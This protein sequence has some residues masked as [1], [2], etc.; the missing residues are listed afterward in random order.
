[1]LDFYGIELC[2]DHTGEVSKARNWRERFDNLNWYLRIFRQSSYTHRSN[3]L[4]FSF[5][6][7]ST[8]HTHN[9][10]RITRIIK[11][12]GILGFRHFQAPLVKFFLEETLVHKQLPNV[13]ES[14]L[15][16]FMF[17]VLEREKRRSLINYAYSHYYPK[18]EFVWC[19]KK[20]QMRWQQSPARQVPKPRNRDDTFNRM[21]FR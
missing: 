10:L 2:N 8:S 11:C 5:F 1:M 12:L 7:S 16:Y 9:N 18:E 20:V 17:A 13:K 4:I 15:N 6:S 14:V 21:G 3:Q 19:P